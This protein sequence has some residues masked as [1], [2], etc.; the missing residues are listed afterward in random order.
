MQAIGNMMSAVAK[1]YNAMPRIFYGHKDVNDTACPGNIVSDEEFVNSLIE[2]IK[3]T[4]KIT[5]EYMKGEEKP[6]TKYENGDLN[7]G[8]KDGTIWYMPCEFIAVTSEFGIRNHPIYGGLRDHFG[9]DLAN[10]SGTPIFATRNG[11][12]IYTNISTATPGPGTHIRIDHGD[13]YMSEYMH[14]LPNSLKVSKGDIVI[15]GD[16]IAEMGSTGGSTGPHLHFG[17]S[18]DP[19]GT[20]H[21]TKAAYVNPRE[22]LFSEEEFFPVKPKLQ[23]EEPWDPIFINSDRYINNSG[24][25]HS[26]MHRRNSLIA[27]TC[28][29]LFKNN[30][31]NELYSSGVGSIGLGLSNNASTKFSIELPDENLIKS[32]YIKS[33]NDDG[34]VNLKS[35]PL[36]KED[37]IPM[38]AYMFCKLKGYDWDDW[39]IFALLGNMRHES[40]LNPARFEGDDYNNWNK[41]VGLVQWTPGTNLTKRI[42]DNM[43]EIVEA[44]SST[45]WYDVDVQLFLIGK[46]LDNYSAADREK[47][48][49]DDIRESDTYNNDEDYKK[50]ID[51]YGLKEISKA[52]FRNGM[53]DAKY[54]EIPE[55][56]KLKLL[57]TAFTYNYERPASLSVDTRINSA[58]HYLEELSKYATVPVPN[59]EDKYWIKRNRTYEGT[60]GVNPY[61]ILNKGKNSTMSSNNAYVWGRAYKLLEQYSS[62]TDC[63][64]NSLYYKL[65]CNV[66]IDWYEFNKENKYFS[67]GQIP[68]KYSIA[69][70]TRIDDNDEKYEKSYVAMVESVIGTDLFKASECTACEQKSSDN[71]TWTTIVRTNYENNWD[72]PVEEYEFKGFIYLFELDELYEYIEKESDLGIIMNS[73][74]DDSN[75]TL[76]F[77]MKNIKHFNRIRLKYDITLYSP[78]QYVDDEYKEFR[79]IKPKNDHYKLY[80]Y[81]SQMIISNKTNVCKIWPNTYLPKSEDD[82]IETLASD[83]HFKRYPFPFGVL[84]LNED[85]VNNVIPYVK[86]SHNHSYTRKNVI[87]DFSLTDIKKD[88]RFK[89]DERN[90]VIRNGSIFSGEN[91]DNSEFILFDRE[92]PSYFGI[93]LVSDRQDTHITGLKASITI[94]EVI[95]YM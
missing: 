6:K 43:D 40:G 75:A 10:N 88:V 92:I 15:A 84:L 25:M 87:Q 58:L 59:Y 95:A 56:T 32:L 5:F 66:N 68:R 65:S 90:V 86:E 53:S 38:A 9:I 49:S 1:E 60:V 89:I 2:Y 17:I 71:M 31:I 63:D 81:H 62:S 78:K 55:S 85:I 26:F 70:W 83:N 14:L 69:C 13:G 80:L 64:P 57:T 37:Q 18:Y 30:H 44:C 20:K 41:G 72:L 76:I 4:H 91:D 54:S 79:Y 7:Y 16:Q 74:V 77:G 28:V 34:T 82:S 94:K 35:G 29:P 93:T 42:D 19:S 36:S 21:W 12:V 52:D 39:S 48:Y 23:I 67:Y 47:L 51:N 50:F 11:K 46:Y 22:Y 33:K 24:N 45:S 61:P 73:T 8:I 3:D 27:S